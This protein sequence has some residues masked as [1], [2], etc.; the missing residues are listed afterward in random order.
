M[1]TSQL[2]L[3][4]SP[5][6][7]ALL[8]RRAREAGQTV[9]AYVLDRVA[10]PAVVRIAEIFAALQNASDAHFPLAALS[11]W[12]HACSP[13][14]MEEAADLPPPDGLPAHLHNLLAAMF[15]EA[16]ATKGVAPPGWTGDVPPLDRPWF[17]SD[18]ASLRAHLLLASPA[19]YRRR[20]LFVD[21]GV[22]ARA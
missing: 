21:V 20:N 17:A 11:E 9:S 1:K 4:L 5:G 18:L 22:G 13:A 19:V 10:P 3:R 7:L 8:K 16:S 15:E 14:E 2:Q 6:Q 12:L